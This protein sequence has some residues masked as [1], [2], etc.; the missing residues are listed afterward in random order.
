MIESQNIEF[1]E[2]WKDEYLKTLCAFANTGGGVLKIGIDDTGRPVGVHQVKRLLREL[3]NKIRNK[4]GIT[5][6]V[7]T[8]TVAENDIISITVSPSPVP[9]SCDGRY[10][11]RSGSN[12]FDLAGQELVHFLIRK[13][14]ITWDTLTG[15]YSIDDVDPETVRTF[16]RLAKRSNRLDTA[17]E[18]EPVDSILRRLELAVNGK[19]TN[20]AIMLFGRD[21]QRFFIN[22]TTRVGRF[23]GRDI[24]IGDEEISGNLIQQF[25]RA[26]ERVK[27]FIDVRYEISADAMQESFQRKEIWDYPLL[28]IREA[29][30]NALIHRDYFNTDIQTQIRVYDDAIRFHNPGSLPQGITIEMLKTEHYSFL[31]NPLIAKIFYLAGFVERYGSGIGRIVDALA[32]A[33]LPEPEFQSD[34]FGFIVRMRKDL[35]FT[36][37]SLR[38][39]GLN[40][41]QLQAM[42][43]ARESGGITAVEYAA[44]APEVSEKTRYRDLL[45]LV[46]RGLLE[47]VGA[48]KGR[49]YVLARLRPGNA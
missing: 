43:F 4:L 27:S 21:P 13:S 32:E 18:E 42:S 45:D 28:A 46:H 22:T 39:A 2:S 44:I 14:R 8:E 36:E 33:G 37:D 26:E 3:P 15:D 20:A 24:I 48:K 5:P 29:L 16:V 30:L 34:S 31:H 38:D 41:R 17:D 47:A 35:R 1:K 40:K 19:L 6:S 9:V 25:T 49:K 23:K 10:Y 12:T 11:Q 7:V